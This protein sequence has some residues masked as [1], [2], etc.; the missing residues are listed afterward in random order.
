LL[1]YKLGDLYRS[2]YFRYFVN[3]ALFGIFMAFWK[4]RCNAGADIDFFFAAKLYDLFN[5]DK[6]STAQ[7]NLG[8]KFVKELYFTLIEDFWKKIVTLEPN[9]NWLSARLLI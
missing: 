8:K 6:N 1:D 4:K 7:M 2:S 9:W 5:H 3:I